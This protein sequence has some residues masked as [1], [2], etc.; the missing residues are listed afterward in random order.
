MVKFTLLSSGISRPDDSY[1]PAVFMH[2][3]HPQS[4]SD[5]APYAHP[6]A[7]AG[8]RVLIKYGGNAMTDPQ[9]IDG[10]LSRIV[11]IKRDGARVVLVHGGGPYIREMLDALGLKSEFIGGHRRT[12]DETIRYIAMVLSGRVNG[13]IVSRLTL[14]GERAVGVSGRD[15]ALATAVRRTH[16]DSKGGEA[17]E[18]D[19]GYVGDIARI[20]PRLVSDLLELGYLPVVSPISTGPEG[21]DYN[22][23]ADMFAGH[24]AAALAVDDYIVLTDVDGL[25][26][27]K[28]DPGSLI[29]Q[30]GTDE[31]SGMMGTVIAG[32]M[33]PK[34]EGCVAAAT[35]GARRARILN[36]TRPQLLP[37]VLAGGHHGTVIKEG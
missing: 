16:S 30:L 31:A 9:L 11:K 28:D 32:G 13:E 10:V 29:E 15:A 26:R 5:E 3:N 7:F 2:T 19:M 12:D 25:Y 36:G 23:N 1:F 33:I 35:G 22:V 24:L 21:R 6:G 4:G 37:E 14:L 18:V 27:D 8:R 17:V 20:D 34:V